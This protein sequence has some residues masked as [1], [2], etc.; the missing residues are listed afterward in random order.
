MMNKRAPRRYDEEWHQIILASRAS[1]LNDYEY[2][3]NSSIPYFD[4][5]IRSFWVLLWKMNK[6][7]DNINGKIRRYDYEIS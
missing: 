4:F 3:R 2:C 1:G 5:G 6:Q 7:C